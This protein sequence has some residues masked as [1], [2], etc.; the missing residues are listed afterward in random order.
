MIAVGMLRK[1]GVWCRDSWYLPGIG[2]QVTFSADRHRSGL[3]RQAWTY[4]SYGFLTLTKGAL[5][6]PS[7]VP[8]GI[9]EEDA[10][11]AAMEVGGAES[12]RAFR[13]DSEMTSPPRMW[14]NTDSKQLSVAWEDLS[15]QMQ[16]MP[17]VDYGATAV[18]SLVA[19][20]RNRKR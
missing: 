9:S 16:V 12:W 10:L 15:G 14:F 1:E 18:E 17:F 3:F 11:F 4:E 20:W 8:P 19:G 7:T 6:R 2:R 13:V 5:L